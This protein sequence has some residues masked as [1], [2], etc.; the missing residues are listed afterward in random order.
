MSLPVCLYVRMHTLQG[1]GE[2]TGKEVTSL[3]EK[4][5]KEEVQIGSQDSD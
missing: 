4:C 1:V 2:V 5:H 3:S